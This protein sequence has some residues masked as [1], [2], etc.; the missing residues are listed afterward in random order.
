MTYNTENIANAT[1]SKLKK[2]DFKKDKLILPFCD[3]CGEMLILIKVEK[4]ELQINI[5][6]KPHTCDQV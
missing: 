4:L 1:Q 6:I 5:R 2:I 3:S